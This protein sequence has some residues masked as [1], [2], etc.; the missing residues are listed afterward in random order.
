VRGALPG[1]RTSTKERYGLRGGISAPGSPRNRFGVYS[2]YQ[3]CKHQNS[4]IC[5]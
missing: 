2:L 5:I 1:D 4:I 3:P